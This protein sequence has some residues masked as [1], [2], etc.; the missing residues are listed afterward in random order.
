MQF[1]VQLWAGVEVQ[2]EAE[3]VG[4][5]KLDGKEIPVE[6]LEHLFRFG[7]RQCIKDAGA[8]KVGTPD[9]DRNAM[10]LKKVH[11]IVT[12]T[13]REGSG[14]GKVTD[15]VQREVRALAQAEIRAKT[16]NPVNAAWV[17]AKRAE[18]KLSLADLRDAMLKPYLEQHGERLEAKA[19][20]NLAELAGM[21]GELDIAI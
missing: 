14:G 18:T 5:C 11:A 21:G 2:V 16:E 10:A 3:L 7:V 17:A 4:T 15:P 13:L 9:A 6:M 19:V 8:A 1:T 12:G 20:A